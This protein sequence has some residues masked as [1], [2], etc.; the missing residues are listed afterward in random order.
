MD[1]I[2]DLLDTA[3]LGLHEEFD[4]I[5]EAKYELQS[6]IEKIGQKYD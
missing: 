1:P 6:I 3:V 4:A 5:A 2:L